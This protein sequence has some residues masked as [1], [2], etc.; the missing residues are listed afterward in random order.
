MDVEAAARSWLEGWSNAWPA[1]DADLV[2]SLYT[3]DALFVPGSFRDPYHGGSGAADYARW[4]FEEQ[5]DVRCWFAEPIVSPPDRAVGEW[6]AII[7]THHRGD[8]TIAGTSMLRFAPDG[9][10]QSQ[11]D[12]W[13]QRDGALKPPAWWGQ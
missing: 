1:K 11:R 7:T 12:T 8:V 4:A 5:A 3:E 13:F 9:R 6:W 10:V 2:G